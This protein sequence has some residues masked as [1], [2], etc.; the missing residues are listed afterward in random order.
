MATSRKRVHLSGEEINEAK[1]HPGVT[2]RTLGEKFGCGKTQI[3][4]ILR[5]KEDILTK[6]AS[7]SKRLECRSSLK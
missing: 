2:V 3:S 1:K 5:N 4:D 6:Y 7:T